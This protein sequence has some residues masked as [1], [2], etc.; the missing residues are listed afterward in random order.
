LLDDDFI[1]NRAGGNGVGICGRRNDGRSDGVDDDCI[2]GSRGESNDNG[3][4]TRKRLD[5]SSDDGGSTERGNSLDRGEG[6]SP[7]VLKLLTRAP[8]VTLL[9]GVKANG[10]GGNPSKGD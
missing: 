7:G 6:M 5:R 8:L 9:I 2:S 1:V 4:S 3:G 10:W